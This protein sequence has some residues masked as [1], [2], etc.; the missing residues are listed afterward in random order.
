MRTARA[1]HLGELSNRQPDLPRRRNDHRVAR[2]GLPMSS[3]PE[4]SVKPGIPRPSPVVI[5]AFAGSSLRGAAPSHAACVRQ[6][7]RASTMSPAA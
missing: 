5:G 7:V 3:R 2:P 1:R 4:Y 6:P